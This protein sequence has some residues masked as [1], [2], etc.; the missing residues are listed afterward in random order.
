MKNFALVGAA[1]FI[2]PRHMQAI[3][4]TGNRLVLA[5]DP[6]DSVGILDSYAKDAKFFTEY[7]VFLQSLLNLPKEDQVDYVS[8]C[9]PNFLHKTHIEHALRNG[10]HA[11]CEKPLVLTTKEIDDLAALEEATGRRVYTVLQLRVHDAIVKLKKEVEAS[12]PSAK[13]DIDL[14]YFTS[15]GHWYHQTWKAHPT[16]SGGLPSNIGIHF[17]DMLTWLFGDVE[18]SELHFTNEV[19]T[20]GYMELKQARVRWILSIDR[21]YLPEAAVKANQSTYRSI[22]IDGKEIEFS[23]GFTDLHTKVYQDIL[24]GR[25]YGPKEAKTAIKIVEDLRKVSPVQGGDHTHPLLRE[26]DLR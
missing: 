22:T 18:H 14:S 9:S 8:I 23:G 12:S 20:A 25:G 15:R 26:I 17:F 11:I 19:L 21:K 13:R 5:C 16:R 6:K 7:E 10:A 1:G 24:D 3:R 2:A 4:D